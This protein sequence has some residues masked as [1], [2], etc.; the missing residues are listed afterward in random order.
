MPPA[1]MVWFTKHLRTCTCDAVT[2]YGILSCTTPIQGSLLAL[3]VQR[4]DWGRALPDG[5]NSAHF[6]LDFGQ[7]TITATHQRDLWEDHV[8]E[9]SRQRAPLLVEWDG[10]ST[11]SVDGVSDYAE[12]TSDRTNPC[13][14]W[15]PNNCVAAQNIVTF[16]RPYLSLFNVG[17]IHCLKAD[18][19]IRLDL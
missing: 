11:G 15:C 4:N 19:G 18:A 14:L 5:M 12:R 16:S 1:D 2:Q 17:L 8:R 3:C 13:L 10:S 6:S 7:E 9:D